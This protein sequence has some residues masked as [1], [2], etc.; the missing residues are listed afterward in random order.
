M[1]KQVAVGS[2]SISG[3]HEPRVQGANPSPFTLVDLQ[4]RQ[5]RYVRISLTDRCNYR[6]TYCMPSEGVE[7]VARPQ[8]LRFEEIVR[9]VRIFVSMGITRVRLTGG[10]PLT[11]R[12]VVDLIAEISAVEG[13]EDLAM[14][15]NGHRLVSLAEPLRKAGL[16]RLNISLNTLNADKFS[17]I[18]RQG[19]L[20]HV[21]D[22][23]DASQTAGFERIK[24]NTVV[25]RGVNEFDA[26]DLL[27]YAREGGHVFRFIE[28]MLIGIDDYWGFDSFISDAELRV[29]LSKAG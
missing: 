5:V 9:L 22:G 15:T 21:L 17:S 13:L 4:S 6:C 28:Y 10:E 12:R 14:T 23:I 16:T 18:T 11:R 24:L 2:L 1:N 3:S 8:L 7:V 20:H 27:T 19:N 26:S 25:L 29:I